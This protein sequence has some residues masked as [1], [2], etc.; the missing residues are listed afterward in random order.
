MPLRRTTSKNS[1]FITRC[2][3]VVEQMLVR[4]GCEHEA[5]MCKKNKAHSVMLMAHTMRVSLQRDRMYKRINDTTPTQLVLPSHSIEDYFPSWA[6]IEKR[7]TQS[8]NNCKA[9]TLETLFSSPRPRPRPRSHTR[10]SSLDSGRN[11]QSIKNSNNSNKT[12]RA[13]LLLTSDSTPKPT[14][15]RSSPSG[16]RSSSPL[17]VCVSVSDDMSRSISNSKF[18]LSTSPSPCNSSTESLESN[19]FYKPAFTSSKTKPPKQQPELFSSSCA[20]KKK[21]RSSPLKGP[22][23]FSLSRDNEMNSSS[24]VECRKGAIRFK[25]SRKRVTTLTDQSKGKVASP[26]S[27]SISSLSSTKSPQYAKSRSSLFAATLVKAP[28]SSL[29]STGKVPPSTRQTKQTKR[30]AIVVSTKGRR[31][32]RMVAASPPRCR[33]VAVSI[34]VGKQAAKQ[35]PQQS[36]PAIVSFHPECVSARV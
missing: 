28:S 20:S 15:G 35:C 24:R 36:T 9:D 26:S 27:T 2:Q 17:R 32:P 10:S 33:P 30:G 8:S 23:S 12:E 5:K 16:R 22:N 18:S 4:A 19:T 21:R 29:S 34:P 13:R 11:K 1:V 14:S 6:T 31:K 25:P 7:R 3:A